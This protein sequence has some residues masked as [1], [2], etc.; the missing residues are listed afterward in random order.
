[1]PE[2]RPLPE[3]RFKGPLTVLYS[4]RSTAEKR[5]HLVTQIAKQAEQEQLP[6]Q[7]QFMGDVSDAIPAGDYPNCHFWGNQSDAAI[8]NEI[9]NNAHILILVSDTEG[10]PMVIMEA[11]A[12]G[13]AIISTAVGEIP[14]HVQDPENGILIKEYMNEAAVIQQS[15]AF[16][17]KALQDT[18]L[19][20]AIAEKNIP[21]AY[22]HFGIERFNREYR[23]VITEA[24]HA[25]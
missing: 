1:L 20:P 19:L 15:L 12:R 2:Q 21:Y 24:K 13:L 23:E 7:F 18:S 11:M 4:G 8:I 5:V 14:V 17:K 6:V 10:F 22:A 25:V 9:Y 3:G 16:I